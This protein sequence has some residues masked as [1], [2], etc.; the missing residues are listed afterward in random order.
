MKYCI[1]NYFILLLKIRNQLSVRFDL[2]KTVFNVTEAAD[3]CINSTNCEFPLSFFSSENV[4]ISVP[5]PDNSSSP[6]WDNTFVAHC[7]CEPRMPLY[8]TF[9]VFMPILFVFCA[10][11]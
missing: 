8:L 3:I 10:F 11:R 9:I 4:V 1:T 6:D 2:L 5:A 7:I